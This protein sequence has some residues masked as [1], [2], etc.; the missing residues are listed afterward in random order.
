MGYLDTALA[1]WD[2]CAARHE[3]EARVGRN[4]EISE[5][6]SHPEPLAERWGPGLDDPTEGVV[7]PI[8]WR[9]RVADL[10]HNEWTRWR[11]RAGELLLALGHPP[12]AAEI[13]EADRRAAAEQGIE[14]AS[15][16]SEM[17]Q[18]TSRLIRK[19]I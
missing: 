15:K 14:G 11:A 9:A 4:K 10:T 7:V 18:D 6:K 13:H 16:H 12:S 8:G 17:P 5:T 1:I 19:P 3:A 2:E